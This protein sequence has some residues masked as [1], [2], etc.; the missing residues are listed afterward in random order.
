MLDIFKSKRTKALEAKEREL[1]ILKLKIDEVKNWCAADSPDIGFCMIY[2]QSVNKRP[3]S[4]DEFRKKLR[5]GLFTF[6]GF[7]LSQK[8]ANK[9]KEKDYE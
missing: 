4:I 3:E 2:L 7:K 6:E 8:M 9:F 5:S 1:F